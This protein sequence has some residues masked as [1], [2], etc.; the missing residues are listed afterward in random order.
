MNKLTMCGIVLALVGLPSVAS[1]G[2]DD[3]QTR[4]KYLDVNGDGFINRSEATSDARLRQAWNNV[5]N[6]KDGKL[7]EKEF[8][9][10]YQVPREPFAVEAMD[11][12][13]EEPAD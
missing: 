11:E 12:G 10:F 9:A 8:T 6:D 1:A 7:T 4:F 3:A 2:Q 13:G 5:D